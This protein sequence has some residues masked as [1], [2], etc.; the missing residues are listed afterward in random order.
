MNE[1]LA[2]YEITKLRLAFR[3]EVRGFAMVAARFSSNG[4]RAR[5]DVTFLRTIRSSVAT[6]EH[7]AIY[8][9]V[10]YSLQITKRGR[11][12]NCTTAAD[13]HAPKGGEEK[14]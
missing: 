10:A 1:S 7:V 11:T 3:L 5:V 12:R 14:S 9:P 8:I 4:V 13:L 2:V 6:R